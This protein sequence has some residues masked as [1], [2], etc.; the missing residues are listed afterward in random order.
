MKYGIIGTGAIGGFY[1]GMLA[2]AG[3]DVHFLLNTDYDEVK[4]NGLQI[5]SCDGNFHLDKVNVYHEV[6]DMPVCDVVLVCLKTVKNNLLESMLPNIV[7]ERTLVVLIQ[8][9]IGLESDLQSVFPH[10]HIAAGLAFICSSKIGKGHI[11]HQCYGRLTLAPF[12]HEYL[13]VTAQ[14]V[15]DFIRSGVQ[16]FTAEY[17]IA[18]WKKA[19]WNVPFNGLTVALNTTTDKLLANRDIEKQ[20]HNIMLEVIHAANRINPRK[21]IDDSFAD[22]MIQQTKVMTPYS[23]SMKL[24]F[25]NRREMEIHYLYE[26]PFMDAARAGYD[27]KRVKFLSDELRFIQHSYIM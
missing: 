6:S 13:D 11:C 19:V 23:P 5:D 7:H 17:H 9:G 20:I 24:D 3:C 2:H 26:R 12:G 1:G 16:A 14:V 22:E 15:G 25:D 8:N 4:A 21:P 27:M 10:L 18:R